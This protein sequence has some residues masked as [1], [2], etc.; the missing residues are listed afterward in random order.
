MSEKSRVIIL[1]HLDNVSKDA[2]YEVIQRVIKSQE[3]P[4]KKRLVLRDKLLPYKQHVRFLANTTS[5]KRKKKKIRKLMQVGGGALS[6]ILEIAI[7][8]LLRLYE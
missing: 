2:L 1:S 3:V 6:S 8:L 4:I 7:P 5:K